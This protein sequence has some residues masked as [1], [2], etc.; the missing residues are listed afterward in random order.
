MKI[1]NMKSPKLFDIESCQEDIKNFR[2]ELKFCDSRHY[3]VV[4]LGN[5]GNT[6]SKGGLNMEDLIITYFDYGCEIEVILLVSY[7]I[8][9]NR[10]VV[11]SNGEINE[12]VL[13]GVND[14]IGVGPSG[15]STAD[16]KR[17]NYVDYCKY[18]NIRDNIPFEY[19]VELACKLEM[20]D[21]LSGMGREDMLEKLREKLHEF[22]IA[23]L[24]NYI[25]GV[26]GESE[27]IV[28]EDIDIEHHLLGFFDCVEAFSDHIG[29][30]YRCDSESPKI[31]YPELYIIPTQVLRYMLMH[32]E[33]IF[34]YFKAG[35]KSI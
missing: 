33:S 19:G 26:D 29:L 31:K 20:M 17:F 3:T 9:C 1:L 14:F 27:L 8:C 7:E 21:E 22:R 5:G 25:T 10:V 35:L 15:M 34:A 2:N 28:T 23:N 4:P 13:G 32:F 18:L 12:M 24:L 30:I 11:P 16:P 6:L